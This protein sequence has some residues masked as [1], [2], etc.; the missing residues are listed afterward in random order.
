MSKVAFI[1]ADFQWEHGDV[2]LLHAR[3]LEKGGA[4]Q[5]AI[6]NAV[7]SYAMQY[8][9]WE[10]GTLARSP[11]TASPPGGGHVIYQTPYARYLYYGMVMGP[12]I[13]VFEDDSGVPTR[14]YSPPGKEKHLTGKFLTYKQDQNPLAGAFWIP[15]M[16][17]AHRDDILQE[18]R[19]VANRK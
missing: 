8:C 15:R 6:D 9:P 10:T 1:K 3:N 19:R 2:D 18:A 13:P 14:F 16:L 5:V 11:Y 12:N 7:I 17:A 4:V